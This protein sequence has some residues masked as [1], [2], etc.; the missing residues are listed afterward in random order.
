MYTVAPE[1][2]PWSER[3]GLGVADSSLASWSAGVRIFMN[4]PHKGARWC[5]LLV[6]IVRFYL[7][8]GLIIEEGVIQVVAVIAT[9]HQDELNF[10]EQISLF[11]NTSCSAKYL[12]MQELKKFCP[13][14]SSDDLCLLF[15]K[16]SSSLVWKY[17]YQWRADDLLKIYIYF[18]PPDVKWN[19]RERK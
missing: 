3:A 18:L 14:R 15:C 6:N 19:Y 10:K 9:L 17:R 8:N 4:Q 5:S 13:P 11:F 2:W 1:L 12:A 16:N 7:E